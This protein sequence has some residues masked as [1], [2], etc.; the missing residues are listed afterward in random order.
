ML[1]AHC[2]LTG[3]S[4]GLGLRLKD[5]LSLTDQIFISLDFLRV[6]IFFFLISLFVSLGFGSFF[7]KK[8]EKPSAEKEADDVGKKY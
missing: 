8:K 7:I 4:H 1:Q 2:K 6:Y 3:V 5:L